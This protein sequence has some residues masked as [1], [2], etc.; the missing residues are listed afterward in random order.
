MFNKAMRK[1]TNLCKTTFESEIAEQIKQEDIMSS[2]TIE[3]LKN[4]GKIQIVE[5]IDKVDETTQK[6]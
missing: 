4:K 2:K 1:F 5:K 6:L 3:T